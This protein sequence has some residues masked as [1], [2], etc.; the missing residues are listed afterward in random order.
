MSEAEPIE[1]FAT[2]PLVVFVY[3]RFPIV[4]R[5]AVGL[6][7]PLR[8]QFVRL[9]LGPHRRTDGRTHDGNSSIGPLIPPRFNF[10]EGVPLL[11]FV[12]CESV[13]EFRLST[14]ELKAQLQQEPGF[15]IT[16]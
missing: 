9:N 4:K 7:A 16:L 8:Y 14:A 5:H 3:K 1:L 11:Q 12:D 2:G 15:P 6:L 10:R 13:P